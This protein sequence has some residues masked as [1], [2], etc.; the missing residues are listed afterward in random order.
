[1]AISFSFSLFLQ[2]G[3][4]YLSQYL[5]SVASKTPDNIERNIVQSIEEPD[6]SQAS[7]LCGVQEILAISVLPSKIVYSMRH[8]KVP[9]PI[10]GTAESYPFQSTNG[11]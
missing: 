8:P 5:L 7:N 1:M 6:L 10:L 9:W 2:C 3:N 4:C 11:V